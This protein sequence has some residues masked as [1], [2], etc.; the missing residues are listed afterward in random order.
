MALIERQTRQLLPSAVH[1]TPEQLEFTKLCQAQ[2]RKFNDQPALRGSATAIAHAK[3]LIEKAI[4]MGL[5]EA[6]YLDLRLAVSSYDIDKC[7]P[8]HLRQI[9]R[10]P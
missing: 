1:L 4:E 3:A 5:P 9:K 8:E 7:L 2:G 6:A 10:L